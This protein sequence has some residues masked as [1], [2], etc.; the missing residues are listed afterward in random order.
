[1]I[2]DKIISDKNCNTIVV[3]EEFLYPYVYVYILQLNKANGTTQSQTII[4]EFVEQ[5]VQ[6]N[7]GQDGFYTLCKLK[8]KRNDL[9]KERFPNFKTIEE[10]YNE[11]TLVERQDFIKKGIAFY[12]DK[13]FY[14]KE[15]GKLI[16]EIRETTIEELVQLNH[17]LTNIDITYYYYFQVCKL[18]ACYAKLA[19][20]VLDERQGI[21]CNIS[22]VNREDIYLRDLV[23][24][25]LNTILYMAEQEQ[26]EEAERLLESIVGCNGLC[27]DEYSNCG[28]QC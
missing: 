24:S 1:M 15:P 12:S 2:Y 8:I 6:F 16:N 3:N 10:Q 13:K 28:C 23:W 5:K 25:A 7:I 18:R 19:Q 17:T 9:S 22:G 20:K 27:D 14:Y 11:M 26:F 21:K 4:R